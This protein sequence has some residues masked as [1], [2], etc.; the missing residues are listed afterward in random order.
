M[1][2]PQQRAVAAVFALHGVVGGSFATRMPWL[3]ENLQLDPEVLGL[4]LLCPSVGSFVAMPMTSRFAHRYGGRAATRVLLAAWSAALVLPVFAPG[5]PWLC[6]ALLVWGAAAGS[7]DIVMNSLGVVVERRLARSIMS[8]LHGMWSVGHLAG[9]GVG[10]L[11]AAAGLD[12]RLHL[13]LVS[14]ALLLAGVAVGRGLPQGR[15]EP[16]EKKPPRFAVPS[17]AILVIGLVGLCATFTELSGTQWAAIYT[18]D[19]TGASAGAGATTYAVFAGF[20][21]AT[22]LSGD[23]VVRRL[24]PVLT[25]RVCSAVATTGAAVVVLGRTPWLVT[26]GFALLAT[27]VAVIVPLVI[28]SAGKA[29]DSP[30]VGVAG[31]A[32]ITYLSGLVAPAVT[33]WVAGVTAWPVAFGVIGVITLTMGFLSGTLR[34]RVTAEPGTAA[35]G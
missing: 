7:C 3:Q 35:A 10:A 9:A 12:A 19:V 13:T 15:P 5:L 17:R 34:P 33:G 20:M 1:R 6:L 29:A 18:V 16:G 26:A 30:G 31:V 23:L 4:A 14:L 28:A 21:V 32:T 2:D 27:G 11:A 24:G 25:V 22:R 8:G